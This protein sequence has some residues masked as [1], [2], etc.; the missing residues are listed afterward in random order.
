MDDENETSTEYRVRYWNRLYGRWNTSATYQDRNLAVEELEHQ[1][2][3]R[4]LR[5]EETDG[6]QHPEPLLQ[7][8]VV[9]AW[10]TVEQ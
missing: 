10:K 3:R 9:P 6:S 2:Q 1:E 5:V 4:A 8:R 7:T